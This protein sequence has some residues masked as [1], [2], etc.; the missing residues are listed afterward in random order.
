MTRLKGHIP[1]ASPYAS[2]APAPS[3]PG[4]PQLDLLQFVSVCLV[5]GFPELST[6]LQMQPHNYCALQSQPKMQLTFATKAHCT[7]SG[8]TGCPPVFFASF[9]FLA[10]S[11]PACSSAWG[12]F[13]LFVG[14]LDLSFFEVQEVPVS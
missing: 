14:P 12:C 10:S 6:V 3:H 1:L 9:S 7:L 11:L 4:G 5:V 2:G 13:I 8:L